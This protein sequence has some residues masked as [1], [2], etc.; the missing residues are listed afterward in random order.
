MAN[1]FSGLFRSNDKPQ[2]THPPYEIEDG[3]SISLNCENKELSN[4]HITTIIQ[5]SAN[6]YVSFCFIMIHYFNAYKPRTLYEIIKGINTEKE[7]FE[8][9]KYLLYIESGYQL[10]TINKIGFRA[11]KSAKQISDTARAVANTLKKH[12]TEFDV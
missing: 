6:L 4:Q 12:I 9:A 11:P 2:T 3:Y 8:L 5:I 10:T 1:F 7:F